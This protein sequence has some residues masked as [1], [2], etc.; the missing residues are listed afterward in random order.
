M[1]VAD[2][3]H[4]LARLDGRLLVPLNANLFATPHQIA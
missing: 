4:V 2:V 1:E 3:Q